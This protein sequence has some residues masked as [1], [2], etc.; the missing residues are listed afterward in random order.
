MSDHILLCIGHITKPLSVW[1]LLMRLSWNKIHQVGYQRIAK[2]LTI[3]SGKKF[4][5]RLENENEIFLVNWYRFLFKSKMEQLPS[6]MNHC[7]NH[8]CKKIKCALPMQ[9]IVKKTMKRFCFKSLDT[10]FLLTPSHE[11]C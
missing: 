6:A 1:I 10:A 4:L 11:A 7:T 3:S 9:G 8:F 5:H 2:L